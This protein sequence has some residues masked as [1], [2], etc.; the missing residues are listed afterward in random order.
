VPY[1]APQCKNWIVDHVVALQPRRILDVGPGQG[2]YAQLLRGPLPYAQLDAVEIWPPYVDEFNLRGQYSQVYVGDFLATAD[3]LRLGPHYDVVILGDVIEHFDAD[4]AYRAYD[5][6][7]SLGRWVIVSTPVQ[8]W[9]QGTEHG[10]PYEE[11]L[12]GFSLEELSSLPGVI[13]S[14]SEG[15]I[16]AI[17]A[18]GS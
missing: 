8:S 14:T 16:G 13:D 6:A 10:N 17:L 18:S 3:Q 5:L 12:H 4:G 2:T 15:S 7:R 1:S 9:P 11:H